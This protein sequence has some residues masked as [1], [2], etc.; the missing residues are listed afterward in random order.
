MARAKRERSSSSF[1]VRAFVFFLKAA[2]VAFALALPL[3]GAWTSSSLAAYG[4]GPRWLAIVAGLLGFPILPLA[5]EVWAAYR[6]KKAVYAK[7]HILTFSDRLWL[8]TLALNLVFAGGLL[9]LKPEAGVRALQA[10]GDWM[11][12]GKH[13]G[14]A[15]GT[16]RFLH[17][18]ADAFDW[19]YRA[20]H[21]N[22]YDDDDG[23]TKQGKK[24]S[25][26]EDKKPPPVRRGDSVEVKADDGTAHDQND[27]TPLKKPD[28]KDPPAPPPSPPPKPEDTIPT[29]AKL[30]PTADIPLDFA[31]SVPADMETAPAAVAHWLKDKAPDELTRARAIHDYI[32]DRTVYDV[33]SL[34]HRAERAPQDAQTVFA[35]KLGVCEGYAR[36]F[37]AMAKEAGLEAAYIVGDARGAGGE[38]D[39][40]GHAW[41]AV[42]AAGNWYLVDATWDAGYLDGGAFKKKYTSEYFLTPAEVFGVDHFPRDGAWQLRKPLLS[43]GEFMRAPQLRPRFFAAGLTLVSPDRSQITVQGSADLEVKK[44]DGSTTFMLANWESGGT[45]K[46]CKVTDGPSVSIHCDFPSA[47]TYRVLLFESNRRY[48]TYDFGGEIV[49]LDAR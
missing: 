46:R 9:L 7:P 22:P 26:D 4:N 40:N 15:E 35:H 42:K 20:A 32:A 37:V 48:G 43:R 29:P 41:N 21:E 2:T 38:V 36:L 28:Q 17:S 14:W 39:G 13:G 30:W 49:A 3:L 44:A 12:D 10:R 45:Q 16:R 27:G 23:G 34:T 18:T 8:R 25:S 5:W 19:V 47:G 6:R 24:T 1:E 11:L 31:V 33:Y